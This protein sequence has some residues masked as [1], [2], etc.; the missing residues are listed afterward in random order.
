M[1]MLPLVAPT[2][3]FLSAITFAEA[4]SVHGRPPPS[5]RRAGAATV[6]VSPPASSTALYTVSSSSFTVPTQE[7]SVGR[8]IREWPQQTKSQ[9]SWEDT[10]IDGETLTRYILEGSGTLTVVGDSTFITK[11]KKFDAGLLVEITGP[12]TVSWA[13]VGDGDVVILTPGYEQGG[14][15]VA[16]AL[17]L[18]AL[19]GALVAGVVG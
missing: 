6:A 10:V 14:L 13:R 2:L 8:G 16:A 18:V 4:F 15:L 1:K 12:A 3:W 17:T 7:E 9:K 11:K 5:S 19:I